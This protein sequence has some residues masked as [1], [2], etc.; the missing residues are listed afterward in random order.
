MK[1]SWEEENRA[2]Q[3]QWTEK[4]CFIENRGSTICMLYKQSGSI[5]KEYNVRHFETKH[6]DFKWRCSGEFRKQKVA[7]LVQTL[8]QQNIFRTSPWSKFC[9]T[10]FN[11]QFI[12]AFYEGNFVRNCSLV[13]QKLCCTNC[14]KKCEAVN[15]NWMTVQRQVAHTQK[16]LQLNFP[17]CSASLFTIHW[18]LMS[19]WPSPQLCKCAYLHVA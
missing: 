8:K 12:E 15:S 9:D 10:P 5:L 7:S 13:S 14:M 3:E 16:M 2:F 4:W 18:L 1:W 11:Y 17:R 19:Q 6:S